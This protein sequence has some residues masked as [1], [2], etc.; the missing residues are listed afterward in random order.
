MSVTF[1]CFPASDVTVWPK[2]EKTSIHFYFISQTQNSKCVWWEWKNCFITEV[3]I[4][5]R[6]GASCTKWQDSNIDFPKKVKISWYVLRS[7]SFSILD[8]TATWVVNPSSIRLFFLFLSKVLFFHGD[9]LSKS[10]MYSWWKMRSFPSF[11]SLT[12]S[13]AT[14]TSLCQNLVDVS[15]H[16]SHEHTRV[17][18]WGSILDSTTGSQVL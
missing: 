3:E 16:L 5:I 13:W 10:R 11:T 4:K 2:R 15:V 9:F 8:L 6:S 14:L 17:P 1:V 7:K 18:D 12:L